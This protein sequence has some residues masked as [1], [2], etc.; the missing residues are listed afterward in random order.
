M[1][2]SR[3]ITRRARRRD[4]MSDAKLTNP[5]ADEIA[6]LHY[7]NVLYWRE[8][9]MHSRDAKAEYQRRQDRLQEIRALEPAQEAAMAN[10]TFAS[11]PNPSD[12]EKFYQAAIQ[13]RDWSKIQ[14]RIRV[15]NLA[16]R[17]RLYEFS[18][19]HYSTPEENQAIADAVKHLVILQEKV[20]AWQE[21]G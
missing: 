21:A 2:W 19:D 13:E 7:A 6:A 16:I 10:H 11:I 17:Y 4:K 14:D 5:K 3:S 20:A 18:Q 9:A 12:W 1:I 8:G 15:A